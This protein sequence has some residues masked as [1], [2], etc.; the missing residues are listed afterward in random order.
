MIGIEA[1]IL[2]LPATLFADR[3]EDNVANNRCKVNPKIVVVH[4]MSPTKV[5]TTHRFIKPNVF[6]IIL[7]TMSFWVVVFKFLL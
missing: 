4:D 2:V 6:S 5:A 7:Q 1:I 3:S